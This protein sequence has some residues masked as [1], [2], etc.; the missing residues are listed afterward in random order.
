MEKKDKPCKPL[1]EQDVIFKLATVFRTGEIEFF[2]TLIVVGRAL[3]NESG[4]PPL[5]SFNN[6]NKTLGRLIPDFRP[7]FQNRSDISQIKNF[8]I[9]LYNLASSAKR[10]IR[11]SKETQ[12]G[13]SLIKKTKSKGPRLES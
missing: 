3:K 2:K 6:S 12:D 9:V 5:D 13:I 1:E 11:V 4:S 8:G 10:A 7:V